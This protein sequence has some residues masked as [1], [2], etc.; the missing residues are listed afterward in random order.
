MKI[1]LMVL[2]FFFS[3]ASACAQHSLEVTVTDIKAQKG[4]VRLAL[5]NNPD[6]FMK[7]HKAVREVVVNG[8]SVQ[9]L[10]ENLEPGEYAISCYHDVNGNKKLDSNFMGVPREPY[11]FSNDA[12]GT[13]GPPGFADARFMVRGNTKI[14]FRVK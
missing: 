10:F 14:S 13:F 2:S 11:G 4:L 3:W 5:Y 1:E 8:T 9:V 7:R 6:D 12:R